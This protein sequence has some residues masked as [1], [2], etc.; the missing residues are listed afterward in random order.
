MIFCVCCKSYV[1]MPDGLDTRMPRMRALDQMLDVVEPMKSLSEWF[2]MRN[3][4]FVMLGLGE[5]REIVGCTYFKEGRYTYSGKSGEH[6]AEGGVRQL[7][8][9]NIL[10]TAHCRVASPMQHPL[11]RTSGYNDSSPTSKAWPDTYN[12]LRSE[13]HPLLTYQRY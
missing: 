4:L 10:I 6:A 12:F 7:L 8:A 1:I 11:G 2:C 5:Y 3:C 9:M 13:T